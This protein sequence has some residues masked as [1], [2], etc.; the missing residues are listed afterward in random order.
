MGFTIPI[1]YA[2]NERS[3]FPPAVLLNCLT[4]KAATKST[5]DAII[6]RACMEAFRQVGTAPIRGAYAKAGLMDGQAF[7]VAKNSGYLLSIDGTVTTLSGTI[8]G[9][10]PVEI[11]GGLDADYNSVIRVATGTSLHKFTWSPDT[12]P[13]PIVDEGIAAT[14]T[15][16]WAGYWLYTAAGDDAVYRQEPASTAWNP[17]DFASAE[18]APDPNKGVRVVGDQAALL[19]SATFEYWY[20][21]GDSTAPMTRSGGQAYDTGCRNIATAVNCKGTL[22]WVSDDSSVVASEGGAPRL[23]SD[24][25]LAEQIRRTAE[26][27]LSASFFV[28]DQHPCYVLHLGTAASW[29]YDLSTQRWSRFSSLSYDY[30]R[31]RFFANMGDVVIGTDRNSNQVWTLDPDSGADGSDPVPKEFYAFVDVPE[32][33]LPLTNVQI[34]AHLGDAPTS[35][36]DDESVMSLQISRD[37]GASWSSPRERGLGARGNRMVQPRW[38]GLGEVK[39]PGAILKF[40]CSGP[41]PFRVSAVRG[42]VAR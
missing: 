12:G 13:G 25:G 9:D 8:P 31:P 41:G 4:E 38:N 27:D 16:F 26:A 33:R 34:D 39:A 30:W 11:D 35:D 23:I 6:G 21:T 1:A 15:A 24:N 2:G 37:D 20:L 18:F 22:I 14:S 10:D 36:P 28:K 17:L 40:A 5:V 7:I 3:G 42:N 29:V 19:G 32:G